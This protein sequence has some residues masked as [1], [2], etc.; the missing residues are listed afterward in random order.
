MIDLTAA[1]M[2]M[3]V[4]VDT[5]QWQLLR[6]RIQVE[7]LIEKEERNGNGESSR[8]GGGGEDDPR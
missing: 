6:L 8:Y 5:L 2:A 3:E 4:K 1:L 7:S